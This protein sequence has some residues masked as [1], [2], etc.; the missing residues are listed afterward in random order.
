MEVMTYEEIKKD[1]E[2]EVPK[3]ENYEKFK[4]IVMAN[5]R[6]NPE[7][8]MVDICT[9]RKCKYS[10]GVILYYKDKNNINKYLCAMR[11]DT[12]EY[13]IFIT[14]RYNDK[15]LYTIFCLMTH[16]ERTRILDNID[17]FQ[18]LWN[19]LW[20]NHKSKY[21][22]DDYPRAKLI[23]D[24]VKPYI[25]QLMRYSSSQAVDPEW[26]WPKGQLNQNE[27]D[28]G[29]TGK[30]RAAVREFKEETRINLWVDLTKDYPSYTEKFRGSNNFIYETT[31]FVIKVDEPP[32]FPNPIIKKGCIREYCIS[33]DFYKLDW[34]EA[35]EVPLYKRRSDFL[36]KID[37]DLMSQSI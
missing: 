23:Y 2:R 32:L 35:S 13:S 31:Y 15:Q 30:L 26:C 29:I 22:K 3:D 5:I 24:Q 14:G 27:R 17:N 1:V 37:E 34:F 11:R 33:A 12:I 6:R 16:I 19:D 10:Y 18:A 28:D 25:K 7:R 9:Q 20:I 4:N 36:K 21:Y 8:K